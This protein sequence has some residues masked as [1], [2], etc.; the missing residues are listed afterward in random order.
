VIATVLANAMINRGGPA[1]VSTTMAAASGSPGEVA[2]AYAATR[3]V[4]GLTELNRLIDQLDGILPGAA[5]LSLYAAVA[6]LLR[7]QTLWFLRNETFDGGL[8]ELVARYALGVSDIRKELPTL[9]PPALG[10]AL[11]ARTESFET[12]GVPRDLARRVA[13]LPLLSMVAD[14]VLVAGRAGAAVRDA[15]RIGFGLVGMFGL[16]RIAA[17]AAALQPADRFDRMALDRALAN[18]YRAQRDLMADVLASDGPTA[19]GRLTNWRTAH[20]AAVDRAV[21]TVAELT[22][23]QLTLSRLAV[24]AGLLSDLARGT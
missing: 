17:S 14:I 12:T 22:E 3:D 1:Y 2:R 7:G 20:A 18:L 23:G 21:L 13:E 8:A 19:A 16:D 5:Q 24:A 10:E 6:S 4:F 15:A 9:L 11:A